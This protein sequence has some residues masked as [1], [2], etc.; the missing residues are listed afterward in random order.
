M[1]KKEEARSQREREVLKEDLKNP[2]KNV[3]GRIVC[4]VVE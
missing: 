4:L 1:V 3:S 2:Q